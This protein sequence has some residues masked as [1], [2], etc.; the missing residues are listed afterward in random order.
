MAREFPLKI[1][2]FAIDAFTAPLANVSRRV[3]GIGKSMENVGKNLTTKLSL[4]LAGFGLLAIKTAADFEKMRTSLLTVFQGNQGAADAAFNQIKKFA[5][6][7]PFEMGEVL[8][9][10]IKLKAYGLDPSQD[11]LE[12]Y[13]NVAS[14]MGKSLDQMVEAVADAATGEFERLKEFGIKA[15]KQGQIT[16]F[17]FRGVTTKVKSNAADIE[18]YLMRIGQVD[19]AGGMARQS[20]TLYGIFSN[21]TDTLKSAAAQIGDAIAK[22]TNL[23]Q[24]MNDL[25][26]WVQK[27]ADAFDG[28]SPMMKQVIVYTGLAVIAL[29]PLLTGLGFAV[30]GFAA[31][32]SPIGL[33]VVGIAAV[34]A[35]FVYAAASMGSFADAAK[36]SLVGLGDII[37]KAL[38][39]PLW[40]F[41]SL[42]SKT[43]GLIRKIP[44][45]G[46]IGILKDA[47]AFTGKVGA[48]VYNGFSDNAAVQKWMSPD[49]A[50]GN[51]D[52]IAAMKS[53]LGTLS[54]SKA[55]ASKSE[56][57]IVFKNPPA[58]MSVLTKKDTNTNLD[59]TQG[60]SAGSV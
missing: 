34:S 13:G 28:L 48:G 40:G 57:S 41:F 31:L 60:L 20:K 15:H 35:T 46:N 33:V 21:L 18:K 37:Y 2:I 47:Q 56:V 9:S 5:K 24:K 11:A 6:D 38:T 51:G 53:G 22:T 10:F 49:T 26:A 7:T 52:T 12:A 16:T 58:G 23:G 30:V 17:T 27:L 36:A 1:K 55:E 43:I 45:L 59:V 29:G 3:A 54:T 39:Y 4:P 14:G 50:T 8:Q 42:L 25:A 19:F 44:G 32:L